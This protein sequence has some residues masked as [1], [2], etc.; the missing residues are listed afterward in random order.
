[1][2]LFW[3]EVELPQQA[4]EFLMT[5]PIITW[6]RDNNSRLNVAVVVVVGAMNEPSDFWSCY[7]T[8][9][10]SDWKD[11]QNNMPKSMNRWVLSIQNNCR[12]FRSITSDINFSH[13]SFNIVSGDVKRMMDALPFFL[14]CVIMTWASSCQCLVD[15]NT[16]NWYNFIYFWCCE[17]VRFT[18]LV[19]LEPSDK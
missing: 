1:M 15:L 2:S 17:A 8:L 3:K 12:K 6:I 18:L 13:V 16:S 11:D 14:Q 10:F 19:W 7:I 5:I 4:F 9:S